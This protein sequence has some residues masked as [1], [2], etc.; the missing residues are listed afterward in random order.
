METLVSIYTRKSVRLFLEKEIEED[1]IEALMKSAMAAPSAMNR[2]PWHFVIVKSKENKEK[3]ISHMP[4]GKYNSPIIII[5]CIKELKTIPF[6]TGLANCDLSAATENILLA[7]HAMGLGAVWCAIYPS[8]ARAKE[9]KKALKLPMGLTPFCAIYVGY[10]DPN[11]K[12]KVKDKFQT[13]NITT[14]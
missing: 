4:F 14:L 7:A 10:P 5:P 13:K 1:K 3:V 9:I 6:N 12:G 11:D 8:K 2:Q